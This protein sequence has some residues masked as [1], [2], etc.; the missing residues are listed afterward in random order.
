MYTGEVM[1]RGLRHAVIAGAPAACAVPIVAAFACVLG[2]SVLWTRFRDWA[3]TTVMPAKAGVQCAVC[4]RGDR[5]PLGVLGIRLRLSSGSPQARPDG[6]DDNRI[7]HR[8]RIPR[9]LADGLWVCRIAPV[10]VMA[11]GR[12]AS[13]PRCSGGGMA[14]A[15][16]EGCGAPQGA[17]V[18]SSR[19]PCPALRK[20]NTNGATPCGAPPRQASAQSARPAVLR[21]LRCRGPV[22]IGSGERCASRSPEEGWRDP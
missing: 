7:C 10:V 9:L 8:P 3:P 2:R 19:H 15:T 20:P 17:T 14:L 5:E 16:G 1:H 13:R 18:V 6:E 21:R 12:P 11:R 4:S 22:Q